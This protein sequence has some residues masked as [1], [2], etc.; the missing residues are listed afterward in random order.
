MCQFTNDSNDSFRSLVAKSL[1]NFAEFF[2]VQ[3]NYEAGPRKFTIGCNFQ[4]KFGSP[5]EGSSETPRYHNTVMCSKGETVNW[6]PVK[7]KYVN[8]SFGNAPKISVFGALSSIF[9]DVSRE[10]Y[11]SV[12]NGS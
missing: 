9:G 12:V 1:Q 4:Q 6:A 11:S 5:I 10:I 8:F 2:S 3:S 7:P